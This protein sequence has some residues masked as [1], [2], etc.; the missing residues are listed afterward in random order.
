MEK[1]YAI[2]VVK[3]DLINKILQIGFPQLR[4]NC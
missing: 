1:S 3:I 2:N 4:P